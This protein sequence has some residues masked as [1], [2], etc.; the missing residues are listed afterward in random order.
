MMVNDC[1]DEDMGALINSTIYFQDYLLKELS[2][3][4][5][6]AL[7]GIDCTEENQRSHSLVDRHKLRTTSTEILSCIRAAY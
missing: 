7:D 4:M 2:N 5:V 6:L 1:W 3:P